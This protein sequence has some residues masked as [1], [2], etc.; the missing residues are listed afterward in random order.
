[1]NAKLK[2]FLEAKDL[3]VLQLT[4]DKLGKLE[5]KDIMLIGSILTK[6]EPSLALSNLLFSPSILP[7]DLQNKAILKGI[8]DQQNQYI[9]LAAIVGLQELNPQNFSDEEREMIV[10]S[11]LDIIKKYQNALA[12]RASVSILPF[13]DEGKIGKVISLLSNTSKTVRHNLLGWLFQIVAHGSYAE[14]RGKLG[15]KR[16]PPKIRKK[17]EKELERD[18]QAAN[19]GMPSPLTLPLY[20]YIPMQNEM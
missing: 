8:G 2:S 17:I 19:S 11:L 18:E 12:D 16:V 13:L 5:E 9:V 14:F 20:S 10:N 4:K 3:D 1:M 7:L 6:W 15:Q